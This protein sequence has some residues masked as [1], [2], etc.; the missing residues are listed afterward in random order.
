M[1]NTLLITIILSNIISLNTK[2]SIE[3]LLN[4]LSGVYVK[5]IETLR[6]FS[7]S[8][9]IAFVQPV[10]HRNPSGPKFTQRVFLSHNDIN[11]PVV[12]ETS[13]YDVPWHKKRQISD[14]LGANQVII[15]HRYYGSSKPQDTQ[16]KYLNT[17]QAASDH[18]NIISKLKGIYK[19]SWLSTGKSKGG[20]AALFLEYY[21]PETVDASLVFVAPVIFG[22][23]DIRIS[24]F[25]YNG[26][27]DEAYKRITEF[28]KSCLLYRDSLIPIIDRSNIELFYS[29][30]ITLELMVL[31]FPYNFWSGNNDIRS[32]PDKTSSFNCFYRVLD[33][34][35][36]AHA[37]SVK[38]IEYNYPL[39]YQE[40]TEIGYYN[41]GY[42]HL[43]EHIVEVKEPVIS[44]FQPP[45]LDI[46]NFNEVVMQRISRYLENNAN[47][48][49]Y[50]YGENDI[51]TAA[52]VLPKNSTNSVKIIV[53]GAGHNFKLSDLDAETTGLIKT[54]L[55]QWLKI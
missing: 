6:G 13:G 36:P 47:N 3:N 11:Q 55:N 43:S 33:R 17:W 46:V 21:Y 9:E 23:N 1:R 49:I 14:M 8:Y 52:A 2:A 5:K 16:W 48:I 39:V 42:S 24:D 35:S 54:K 10:D 12:C 27:G 7:E 20:M 22:V 30:S 32:L 31:D 40:L 41:Y 53:E 18:K 38:N 25:A 19:G 51:W 26:H 28:Q 45:D 44:Y 4:E 37:Y 15:E 34:I 29:A 50:L